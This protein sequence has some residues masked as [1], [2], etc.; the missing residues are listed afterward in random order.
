MSEYKKALMNFDLGHYGTPEA[1]R[2]G[3]SF[4]AAFWQGY[5]GE[6]ICR[7]YAEPGS[8]TEQHYRAG[9]RAAKEKSKKTFA[10]NAEVI[11]L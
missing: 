2:R 1:P 4:R 5:F 3:S 8:C 9:R 11:I 7:A 10:L 6:P